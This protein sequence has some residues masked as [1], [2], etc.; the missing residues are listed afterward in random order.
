MQHHR[1]MALLLM[2]AACDRDDSS[3]PVLP[4]PTS[5][6]EDDRDLLLAFVVG[7]PAYDEKEYE[8]NGRTC[9]TCHDA[10]TGTLSIEKINDR[11]LADPE[12]PLFKWDGT[13]DFVSG[14]DRI[15]EHGT[16]LIPLDLPSGVT[17]VE[18]PEATQ[19]V[20]ARGTP[21]TVNIA[22]DPVL[23]V[24]GREPDLV[25]QA[26]NAIEGH[27]QNEREPSLLELLGIEAFQKRAP[28]FFSRPSL[29][30]YSYSGEHPLLAPQL[31]QGVTASEKRGRRF[32]ENVPPDIETGAG[33][34][35]TCHGGPMLNASNEFNCPGPFPCEPG[36][37]GVVPKGARFTSSLVSELNLIGN[38]VQ[39]FEVQTPAGPVLVPSPDP[40]RA[41]VTN[42][43]LPFPLG[44]LHSFKTP[45]LW[46]VAKTGPYMHDNSLK[47]L[48][49]VAA[50]YQQF[51]VIISTLPGGPA[52]VFLDDQDLEDMVA[53]LRLL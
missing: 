50:H 11:F 12:D 52:P 23:M 40:G 43:W 17:L 38:P 46:G 21:T 37:P 51:F 48:E 33:I 4:A 32:F 2:L 5:G 19:V 42:N 44:D 8:G 25:S 15:L 13:D 20:V 9:L 1:V 34:C 3:E 47:T 10:E 29:L 31:P 49:D 45:T 41:L 7:Q 27:A 24:D 36:L 53:F 16:F 35:A 14:N 6:S 26:L 22:L 39:T 28:R 30:L 18:D